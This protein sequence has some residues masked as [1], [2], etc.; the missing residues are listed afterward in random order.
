MLQLMRE[1]CLYTYPPLSIFTFIQLSELGKCIVEKLAQG[2]NTAVQDSNPGPLS[3][4]SETL[5]LSHC[6]I[7]WL[8]EGR[9][10]CEWR[11]GECA[12]EQKY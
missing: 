9:V 5:P 8:K 4:E 3:Q 12:R 2:S 6:A 1:D 11:R 7:V 10:Y